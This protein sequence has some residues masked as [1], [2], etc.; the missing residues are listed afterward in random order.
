MIKAL[1]DN[2]NDGIYILDFDTGQLTD[3]N[4]K[5]CEIYGYPK[6]KLLAVNFY[7]IETGEPPY[8]GNEIRQW[9][10]LAAEGEPQLFEWLHKHKDD[11]A[12]WLEVY[13]KRATIA[14]EDRII[15]VVKDISAQKNVEEKLNRVT[16][17]NERLAYSDLLT[18]LPNQARMNVWMER[19]LAPAR[20]QEA[21]GALLSIDLDN[22]KT[23]NE[24]F[25]HSAGAGVI[26]T[27]STYI[28]A[29]VD[30]NGWVAR[31]KGAE[32]IVLLPGVID[33]QK[34]S[35]IA[36]KIIAVLGCEYEVLG[37]YFHMTA[38]AGVALY[39]EDGVTADEILKNADTALHASQRSGRARWQFYNTEMNKG[40]YGKL[41]ME[42]YLRRAL[43]N[44]ELSL[45][46]QPQLSIDR[47]IRG[48][49][50]L[51][52]WKSP[53]YGMVSPIEFIPLAEEVGLIASIG[54]WVMEESCRFARKLKD[55]GFKGLRVAV[56]VSPRQLED[57]GF[58]SKV[59]LAIQRA[60]I[61]P[62]MMEIEITESVIIEGM[63]DS[64]RKLDQIKSMGIGLAL[65][66]LGKGYSSLGYLKMLPV[67]TL[68][69]D[70]SFVD[71][72]I[73]DKRKA[74]MIGSIINMAHALDMV[75]VAEGVEQEAQLRHLDRCRC[76]FVQGY[77]LSHPLSEADAM[78]FL[79]TKEAYRS[80][81]QSGN[82]LAANE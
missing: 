15:G 67:D 62:A 34:V 11:N 10:S 76:D 56:N 68:K 3:I 47:S 43:D 46:Y 69:I 9:V 16:V 23:V 73:T 21:A 22:L 65:D 55:K 80:K 58:M 13:L 25:G 31:I 17:E 52:R 72:I 49:E 12:L 26:V 24:T 18:G 32:F 44:G 77:L 66:D 29:A 75:V 45:R 5:A 33:R 71:L 57:I 28:V 42:K 7:A 64:A 19:E 35:D 4:R 54:N 6:E 41:V 79:T 20:R 39:P 82:L 30:D 27:A 53:Y 1:F 59:E 70:K 14:D 2:A 38:S 78:A 81:T 51:L 36:D 60:G 8:S 48:F 37:E 61:S 40:A 50:A 74:S 63:A